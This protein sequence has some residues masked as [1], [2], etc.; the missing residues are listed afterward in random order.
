[1]RRSVLTSAHSGAT[2][3]GFVERVGDRVP[4]VTRMVRRPAKQLLVEA[5]T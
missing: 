5:L 1:M 2:L 4:L 3:S